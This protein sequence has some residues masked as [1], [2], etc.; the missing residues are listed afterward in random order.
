VTS[1]NIVAIGLAYRWLGR[2]DEHG[3]LF[4]YASEITLAAGRRQVYDVY[5]LGY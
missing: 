5:F 4:R 2:R 1:S 3:N